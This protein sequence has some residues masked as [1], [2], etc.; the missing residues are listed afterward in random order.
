MVIET[1]QSRYIR[2]YRTGEKKTMFRTHLVPSLSLALF[3]IS[4]ATGFS[5]E[6]TVGITPPKLKPGMAGLEAMLQSSVDGFNDDIKNI[7]SRS[8]DKPLFMQG[9]GGAASMAVLLPGSIH[10]E[11]LPFILLGSAASVFSENLSPDSINQIT[12]MTSE[13]D[14]K[15]G[16]CIQPLVI[17]GEFPLTRILKGLHAGANIGFMDAEAGDYGVFSFSSGVSTGYTLFKRR[18]GMA[19]WEGV[20]FDFGADYAINRLT[21]TIKPGMISKIVSI[22]PDDNGPLVPFT[23]TLILDPEIRASVESS[24]ISW[25]LQSTTGGTFFEAFSL[26]AGA[27]ISAAFA[28][29]G[30]AIETDEE[31]N[32]SGYLGNLV[33]TPGRISISGTT[34]EHKTVNWGAYIL[35]GLKFKI[36]SL[37]LSVPVVWKPNDS[38]GLGA[39]LGVHF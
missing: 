19:Q 9:F 35:G 16:V 30:I 15:S 20:S 7:I 14:L 32:V 11:G 29:A 13:S 39:F 34:A 18:K 36:G 31:I 25:H 33:T 6:L 23:T 5:S 26:F 3:F 4:T 17:R 2:V 38:I 21:A 22:D 28:K 24:V 8:L 12:T 10:P 27:G 37:D 1:D